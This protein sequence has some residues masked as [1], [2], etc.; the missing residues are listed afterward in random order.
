MHAIV[1]QKITIEHDTTAP[2]QYT[3]ILPALYKITAHTSTL[4]YHQ[5]L[6]QP[7]SVIE[8]HG[9]IDLNQFHPLGCAPS[10]SAIEAFSGAARSKFEEYLH[11]RSN[12][13]RLTFEK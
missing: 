6:A 1:A 10:T 4:Q 12:K 11:T 13:S 8:D 7:M 5:L 9:G 3:R 2:L